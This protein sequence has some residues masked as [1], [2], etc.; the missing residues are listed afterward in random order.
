MRLSLAI[1]AAALSIA[2]ALSI[3]PTLAQTGGGVLKIHHRDNPPSASIREEATNSTVIPFVPL[4]NNLVVF[5]QHVAQN[6]DRSIM[7]DLAKSW[8]WNA[9]M[10][11]LT[12]ELREGVTWH[13][14][15]LFTAKDVVCTFDMLAGKA[16]CGPELHRRPLRYDLS[17]GSNAAGL[18]RYL[19]RGHCRDRRHDAAGLRRCLGIAG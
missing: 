13:D 2:F 8:R 7:P 6:S 18:R 16:D 12:F 19:D 3:G 4:S 17:L 14:V 11:E 15:R 5:D 10:T 9:E 1:R